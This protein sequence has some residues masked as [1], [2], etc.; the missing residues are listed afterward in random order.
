MSEPIPQRPAS[1][2]NEA[3]LAYW[4]AQG[5][6]WRTEPEIYQPQKDFLDKRRHDTRVDIENGIYPFR[7]ENGSIKLSR[8]D[9]EWLLATHE[10]GGVRGPVDWSEEVQRTRLGLDLRGAGLN[11]VDL[12][13]LPLARVVGG[14]LPGEWLSKT[15]EQRSWAA[16]HLQGANLADTHLE[17]AYLRKAHLENAMLRHA[18]LDDA[19]LHRT[20]MHHAFL[21]GA[22]FAHTYLRWAHLEGAWLYDVI[23]GGADLRG[24]FFDSVSDMSSASLGDDQHGFA[25]VA[26]VRWDGVNLTT[27]LWS[28]IE[29]LGDEREA[30]QRRSANGKKKPQVRLEEFESAVRANRQLAIALRNQGLNERADHFAY[31]AQLVQRAVFRRQGKLARYFGSWFLSLIAGYGYKPMRS[32]ITY[33]VIVCA[34]AGAYLLNAQFAAPHLT[35]DEALVLSISAFHGRGFFTSGISLG[36]TL[37]RLAAGE[38]IIGLLIEITFIATFTQRF[39]AR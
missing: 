2:D 24:V 21:A 6:P 7:D 34:F 36:D 32:V 29:M 4:K 9:V 39:F 16:V 18:Y 13:S 12:H 25:L 23:F 26:D 5:M 35:W 3:W 20:R 10:G 38:A 17:G 14:L 37:A 22:S 33:I 1:S 31:R 15:E 27:L 11:R 28:Q 19:D 30:R 8:A